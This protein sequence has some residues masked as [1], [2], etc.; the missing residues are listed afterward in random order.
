[1]QKF[2]TVIVGA[3]P[4]GLACATL[5]AKAGRDVLVLERRTRIGP[6]ICAGGITWSGLH[7]R[8]PENLVQRAFSEQHLRTP[9]QRT[10]ISARQPLVS[11]VDRE[12]LGQWQLEQARAA[13]VRVE[14]GVV[15]RPLVGN[16]IDAAGTIIDYQY[17]VGA[18]GSTSTIRQHLGLPL[19]EVGVGVNLFA[20]G[21]FP[22]MEWHL[23]PR[24]FHSGYA[25]IFPHRGQASIGAYAHR[26]AIR[27]REL[28]KNFLFWAGKHGITLGDAKLTAAPINFDYRGWRFGNRFLIG[29]AAGLA[30]PLT[31]EGIYPAIISGE[32]VA[33][34]ILDP[35]YGAPE[36][37]ALLARHRQHRR[38]LAL[39]ETGRLW[40]RL[41]LEGL[42]LA[43]RAGLVSF[44]ALEMAGSPVAG[45]TCNPGGS[46]FD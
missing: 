27:P 1:M 5:L 33:R 9:W 38:L 21:D 43:L 26:L 41:A 10:V 25:W 37:V 46:N 22:D 32:E 7:Q 2:H 35:E 39:I 3:G 17:L 19:H 31:G 45:Q 42:V 15:V 6:K 40:R 13:G 36:L 4:A 16:R 11:T 8:L 23:E 14:T 34:A 30:S 24:L 20:P 18:D 28:R 44:T 29:D 12:E